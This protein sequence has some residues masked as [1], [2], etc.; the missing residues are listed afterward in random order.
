MIR[1]LIFS[2]GKLVGRDLEVEALRLV[3]ADKG[4]VIWVDLEDPTDD[5]TKA[6]L[7]GVFQFHPLAIEDC[8]SPSSLPKIEDYDD[9]FFLVAHCVD[10]TRVEK[11][12][13]TEINLFLGR[14]FMVTFHR[15]RMHVVQSVLERCARFIGGVI[16]RGPDRLAHLLLDA[17]IDNFKPVTD[18]LRNE[19]EIIEEK[20]LSE[21]TDRKRA[22]QLIPKLLEV[23]SEI[24]HLREII[25]PL[26]EVVGRLTM[27]NT[28]NIR[29][30]TLPYFRDLRDNLIR[31]D[32]TAATYADQL[33]ISF[34]LY[35]NKSDF[36]ANEGIKTLTALT[37][38]T[39]PATLVGTWYGMNFEN[40]PELRTPLGYP[41]AIGVTLLI[42]AVIWFWCKRRRW[43]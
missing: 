31:I 8:V 21:E 17:L 24:N 12:N 19:L 23:R 1:S 27:G 10:P 42:T 39:L 7:E 28:K 43:I 30:A 14:D 3:R 41:I 4:L 2:E 34:D 5:E 16:A 26:R 25:R 9:Y 38:L 35:L 40:M 37:A 33:L 18:E 22:P 6:I 36:S 11:F 32:E 13:T 29:A 20:V 15:A